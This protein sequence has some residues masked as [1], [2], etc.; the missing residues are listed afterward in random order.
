MWGEA[1]ASVRVPARYE[2]VLDPKSY[3]ALTCVR[4]G[5]DREKPVADRD[6]QGALKWRWDRDSWPV[7]GEIEQK[8]LKSGE[9]R[10]EE[11]R[12]SPQ[13]LGEEGKRLRFSS[14]TVRFNR[15]RNC[16]VL[17]GGEFGGSKSFLGEVWYSE[18]PSAIGPF[19]KAV[20]VVT[21]EGQSFYNVCHHD[22]LDEQDSRVIHFEGTYTNS[23]T[24]NIEPTPRY[25][26]NQM[27]YRLD[28]E[29]DGLKGARLIVEKPKK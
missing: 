10:P 15:Y 13:A 18:G 17:I 11:A 29:A 16:W 24:R 22:A 23:F 8:L 28:L 25:E 6:E 12:F 20:K 5:G 19:S 3:E 21:H 26:Y 27:L 4:A 2:S 14:G 7:T 9:I 1:A